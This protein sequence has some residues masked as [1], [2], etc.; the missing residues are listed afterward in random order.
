METKEY[1]EIIRF[2]EEELM[3]CYHKAKSNP[4]SECIGVIKTILSGIAKAE[5]I[6]AM[7]NEGYSEGN[8]W[9]NENS[10][11]SGRR[12]YR[13]DGGQSN[14]RYFRDDGMD[15]DGGQSERR[16]SRDGDGMS[17]RGGNSYHDEDMAEYLRRRVRSEQDDRRRSAYEDMLRMMER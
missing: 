9:D 14:R 17:N 10:E 7:R 16:Y 3:D 4:T 6:T 11:Y 12:N 8:G 5:T 15:N 2:L 1:K 13:M